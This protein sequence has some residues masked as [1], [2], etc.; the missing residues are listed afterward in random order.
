MK[1]EGL[2]LVRQQ[3][4]KPWPGRINE[5][6]F[7]AKR[8]LIYANNWF[9]NNIIL[10]N[11]KNGFVEQIIDLTPLME[12]EKAHSKVQ[13]SEKCLNGIALKGD[14]LL[15]TGKLFSNAFWIALD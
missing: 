8:G 6:E 11:V 10:I 3:D 7:D 5:L 4:G 1:H 2:L 12:Y 9:E 15:V 13:S 14:R